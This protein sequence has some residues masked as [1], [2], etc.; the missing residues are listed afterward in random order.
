MFNNILIFFR[1]PY[2]LIFILTFILIVLIALLIN[3]S[4][5]I[6]DNTNSASSQNSSSISSQNPVNSQVNSLDI[7]NKYVK[8]NKNTLGIES[9]DRPCGDSKGEL[10]RE[11][12]VGEILNKSIKAKCGDKEIEFIEIKWN[13]QSTGFSE[14]NNSLEL[15]VEKPKLE[16][17][18]IYGSVAYPSEYLPDHKVCA[19]NLINRRD[20][21]CTKN[22][23]TNTTFRS[24]SN[25]LSKMEYKLEVP[26]GSYYLYMETLEKTINN[27][28]AFFTECEFKSSN[29]T[30]NDRK[31]KCQDLTK[32]VNAVKVNVS[33]GE[34]V[35]DIDVI[36]WYNTNIV[37][38]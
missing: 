7:K 1:K 38:R 10:K 18:Y 22:R 21:Y 24:N 3:E 17:G 29:I 27:N 19:L 34:V 4:S 12:N 26:I 5:K 8:V 33:A 6:I 20:I 16:I 13:D 2:V 23:L 15:M 14:V 28:K 31:E 35:R 37:L 36:N 25:I 30:E 11:G 32:S 9:Y